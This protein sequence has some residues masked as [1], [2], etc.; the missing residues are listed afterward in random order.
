MLT[1]TEYLLSLV[2]NPTDQ[3]KASVEQLKQQVA[4]V[5]ALTT[6][7]MLS[8]TQ[9][10]L[11]APPQYWLDLNSYHP[12]DV[13]KTLRQPLLILQGERDYQVTMTDFKG[14]QA[15]LAGNPNVQFKTYPD[16]NHLFISGQ[17]KSTPAEYQQPGHVSQ[18]VVDDIANWVSKR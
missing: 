9:P 2:P 17:G 4:A 8:A 11:G 18:A 16:L 3:Q 15:A 13:A 10:I 6:T 12:A 14:W 5:K 1:Q 7:S